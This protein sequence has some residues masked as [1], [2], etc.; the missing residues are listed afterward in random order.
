MLT[1]LHRIEMVGKQSLIEL[2]DLL[3]RLRPEDESLARAPQPASRGSTT[4][5][6]EV[7]AT[8]L[9]VAFAHEG[10]LRVRS[11]PESSCRPTGSSRRR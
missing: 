11:P 5:L 10:E 4:L 1:A 8:G 7:R 6:G 2:R 3:R 9:D